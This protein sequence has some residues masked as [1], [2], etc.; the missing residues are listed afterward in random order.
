MRAIWP[1]SFL[2]L[3][4]L[5]FAAE[6]RQ[7][8]VAIDGEQ[9]R[10][11][12]KLTYAGRTWNG[13]KIEGLLF[14]SRMVQAIFDDLNP[15]TAANWQYPDTGK[16]DADRNTRDFIAAM[17]EWRRHGL[18]AFTLNLQGGNPRG[19]GAD[20]PWHNSAFTPEGEL[21]PEYMKRLESILDRADDLGMVA[22]LG[23]FYFGQDQRLKDEAAVVRALDRAVDWIVAKGYRNV[24][25]EVNNECNVRYDHE[26][27]KPDRVHE[28]IQR[29]QERTQGRQRLLVGTSYGGGT[30]PKPNVVRASDFLLLHGN[31]VKEPK[32]IAEMV[33]QTRQVDGYRPMPILF[34]EDDHFDFDKPENNFVAAVNE[35]ASWGYFD[36]RMKDEGFHEGYQSVPVDWR[37]SS[38]RK[39]GFFSLLKEIVYGVESTPKKDWEIRRP[40]DVGLDGEQLQR[41]RELVGG[42]GCIV[43][44]GFMA[45]SWGEISEAADLASAAKPIISTLL[46]FAIQEKKLKSIDD[47]VSDVEPGLRDLNE[48]KDAAITWRH[49]ASQTSG[50]GL[51]DAP[52][53]AF[54]YN[55]F[56]LAL[57]FQALMER[58]F[59]D[60]P[61]YVLTTRLGKTVSFADGPAWNA[62]G[63]DRPGR[64]SMSLRDFARF[65][66]LWLRE[67]RWG[68]RQV[69]DEYLAR[70]AQNSPVPADMPLSEGKD[71]AMLPGQKSMG[72]GKTITKVG[73][74]FYSF[75]WW[76]NGRDVHGRRLFRDLPADAFAASGHGGEKMLLIVPSRDVLVVWRTREV[77]DFDASAAD[78]NT[79][80]NRAARLLMAAMQR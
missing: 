30:I 42:S 41:L 28:L 67:G 15:D 50:Y 8:E 35:Y 68:S 10:I 71:A 65:G 64:L 43:R 21:R 27:L 24:M 58:V 37:V 36:Y 56:A 31:G 6:P 73:P 26:I 38:A 49:L 1:T 54:A 11:N 76:L 45:Y 46:L 39:R 79:K 19:Y 16:W 3:T 78:P 52:G 20:Q 7:T 18:L 25:I 13:K 55:D 17:P 9:F 74:G 44:H 51:T 77:R 59:R 53:K 22:I 66:L 40:E 34:N 48:G 12:G 2:F 62:L 70:L 4:T 47:R 63:P 80:C 5:A 60:D 72:G 29:V 32:R 69:L 61:T 75:N 14:N 57:Y 23:I 33:R